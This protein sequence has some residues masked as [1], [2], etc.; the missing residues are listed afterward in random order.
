MCIEAG[1]STFLASD[2]VILE[3][4]QVFWYQYLS[5]ISILYGS[6]SNNTIKRG[7]ALFGNG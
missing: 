4:E 3:R 6:S 5:M 2:T 1:V 7:G